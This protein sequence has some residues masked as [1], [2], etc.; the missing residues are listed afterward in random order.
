M[1]KAEVLSYLDLP[2][3]SMRAVL[4]EIQKV[5]PFGSTV[6]INGPSG[7]GKEFVARALHALSPR[8]DK[9]FIAIN[10]GAIPRDLMESELFGS[11]KGA[12]TGSVRTRAG[13]VENAN[14]GT[15][16][17]D[18][19]GDMP[20]DMQVKL[21]RLLEDRKF[22]RVGGSQVLAEDFRLICATHQDLPKL[23]ALGQFRED[24]YYRINVFPIT[25]AGLEDRRPDIERL[26]G[27][28][29]RMLQNT[30]GFR[31]PKL[32]PS[33][34]TK[35]QEASWPGNIRQLRN[36]LERAS[37]LYSSQTIGADEI[38]RIVTTKPAIERKVE[39]QALLASLQDLNFSEE[40]RS[41]E[42]RVE[43][44]SLEVESTR[45]IEEEI[46]HSDIAK[47]LKHSAAFNLRDHLNQIE[48]DFIKEA[49]LQTNQSV[50]ATAR[51]LGLQRT[52]L[53]EKMRK[54][55]IQIDD[56]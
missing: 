8:E 35:L 38:A 11:E 1:K 32:Q 42:D 52:T 34:I 6:Y 21:L 16:F 26:S 33:A 53:I 24:L 5:A 18:E 45:P 17:L 49:F 9:P 12:Y 20:L 39:T 15:L 48:A 28:I 31:V 47:I 14:G 56:V 55:G 3:V 43:K 23:V 36:V 4:G 29:L 40:D 30:G 27:H 54:L 22:T 19:I 51:L 7:S 44:G 25:L 50:S 46:D 2:S 13:L 37:V 10:C 41:E